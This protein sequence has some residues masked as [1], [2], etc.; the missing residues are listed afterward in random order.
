MKNLKKSIA[1][2]AIIA[3]V[4]FLMGSENGVAEDQNKDRTGAPGSS[5]PCSQNNCH[6]DGQFNPTLSIQVLEMG[7]ELSVSSYIPEVTYEMRFTVTAGTGTPECYGFQATALL[8][9]NA[10]AGTFSN[11]GNL[12]QLE[13]VS[14]R[15][16]VEHSE[17]N[18]NNTFM[19]DWEAPQAGSGAVTIYASSIACNLS[20]TDGGDGYDGHQITIEELST[21]IENHDSSAEI[22]LHRSSNGVIECSVEE[23]GTI[24]VFDMQGKR[25]TQQFL[26][27]GFNTV[28]VRMSLGLLI[29]SFESATQ[30]EVHKIIMQ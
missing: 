9:D 3:A 10:N 17:P 19:V 6:D 4:P 2:I 7:T 8:Q 25:I 12:V 5:S 29:C 30:A 28:D 22:T 15:H 23:P 14:G 1:F 18:P 20:D 11:P 26:T 27:P 24:S 16:I 21:D 13:S